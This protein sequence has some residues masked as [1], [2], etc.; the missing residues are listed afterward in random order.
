MQKII[1]AVSVV[2]VCLAM[3]AIVYH[4]LIPVIIGLF[5]VE[6]FIL[7]GGGVIKLGKEKPIQEDLELGINEEVLKYATP[8]EREEY[9]ECSQDLVE[10]HNR[11]RERMLL[12][13]R[14]KLEKQDRAKGQLV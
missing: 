11:H 6:N 9:M 5:L 2:S 14:R 10:M 4:P 8:E 7:L 12:Q 3:T 1:Y 13:E